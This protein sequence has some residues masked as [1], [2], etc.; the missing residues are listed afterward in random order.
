MH[1]HDTDPRC[2]LTE[3]PPQNYPATVE[4]AKF[5]EAAESYNAPT[6]KQACFATIFTYGQQMLADPAF[7]TL[8]QPLLLEMLRDFAQ[9]RIAY[10][11]GVPIY[12]L[13]T[14]EEVEVDKP[15]Q[16]ARRKSKR[17]K[18]NGCTAKQ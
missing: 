10:V 18:T 8:P 17:S 11:P 7:Q 15:E 14:F 9:R 12:P 13:D 16:T 3:S 5:L 2:P 6:L 1:T 4:I